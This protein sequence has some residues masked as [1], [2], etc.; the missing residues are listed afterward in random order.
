MSPTAI[1]T[2]EPS[3]L[4]TLLPTAAPTIGPSVLPSST[5]VLST[6]SNSSLVGYFH[7][8]LILSIGAIAFFI[9]NYSFRSPYRGYSNLDNSGAANDDSVVELGFAR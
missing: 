7:Y 1:P 6:V 2:T 5:P 9:T 3:P 4:P 8:G